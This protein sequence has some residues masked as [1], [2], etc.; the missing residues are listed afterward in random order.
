MNFFQTSENLRV[1]A[2]RA[3]S[4]A[5]YYQP[6]VVDEDTGEKKTNPNYN[7]ERYAYWLASARE[8]N[9]AAAPYFT[10]CVLCCSAAR[11]GRV[12]RRA[13]SHARKDRLIEISFRWNATLTR[14]RSRAR[15]HPRAV[16]S[17]F[18]NS[19]A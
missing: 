11:R 4:M 12:I 6:Q 15:S 1:I 16:P 2:D 7:E 9:K 19:K 18:S 8:A 17:N 14:R 3:M 13:G 5:A 10:T